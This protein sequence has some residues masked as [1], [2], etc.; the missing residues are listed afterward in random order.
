MLRAYEC[1]HV[2]SYIHFFFMVHAQYFSSQ[3]Y[4]MPCNHHVNTSIPHALTYHFS[5]QFMLFISINNMQATHI[6][7]FSP[8]IS[9]GLSQTVPYQAVDYPRTVPPPS[10]SNRSNFFGTGMHGH[11]RPHNSQNHFHGFLDK[12]NRVGENPYLLEFIETPRLRSLLVTLVARNHF[13]SCSVGNR[14]S[15]R[16]ET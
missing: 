3:Y 15:D 11:F 6:D 8:K 2:N 14:L 7:N 16:R 9:F 10:S 12:N 4:L 13:S 5:P 1:N